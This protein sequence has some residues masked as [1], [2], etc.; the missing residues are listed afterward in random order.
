VAALS[1]ALAEAIARNWDE[2]AIAQS[3][4]RGWDQPARETYDVCEQVLNAYKGRV[5]HTLSASPHA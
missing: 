3:F 1:N 4:R 2:A 5:A